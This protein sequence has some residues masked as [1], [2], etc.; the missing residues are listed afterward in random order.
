[1]AYAKV[2]VEVE[3]PISSSWGNDCTMGQIY[4]QAAD[5]A[6]NR[7]NKICTQNGLRVVGDFKVTA[8]AVP[9]ASK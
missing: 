1:M 5:E 6:R 4:K 8:V 3:V 9:Q 7:M 2:T